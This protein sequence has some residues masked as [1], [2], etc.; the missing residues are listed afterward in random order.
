MIQHKTE[1]EKNSY[2]DSYPGK[3][4]IP[5]VIYVLFMELASFKYRLDGFLLLTEP[6]R[7]EIIL[8]NKKNKSKVTTECFFWLPSKSVEDCRHGKRLC[9]QLVGLSWFKKVNQYWCFWNG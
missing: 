7:V 5:G 6:Q 9:S 8:N 2:H 3:L 4:S 1:E